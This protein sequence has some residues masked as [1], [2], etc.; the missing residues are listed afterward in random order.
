MTETAGEVAVINA[1]I[2]TLVR[3]V[4]DSLGRTEEAIADEFD[5]MA[6]LGG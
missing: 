2:A 1:G 5:A 6:R 4:A 3:D